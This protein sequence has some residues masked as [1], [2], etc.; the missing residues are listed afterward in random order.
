[1]QNI[2]WLEGG[3]KMADIPTRDVGENSLNHRMK[4]IMVSLD[5]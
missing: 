2:D 3:L 4:Y 5:N 1:M